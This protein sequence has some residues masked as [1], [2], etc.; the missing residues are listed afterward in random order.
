VINHQYDEAS[1]D[2]RCEADRV[3]LKNMYFDMNPDK[4]SAGLTSNKPNIL[5]EA[6]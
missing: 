3:H 1:D 6:S 4:K 2:Y 5:S